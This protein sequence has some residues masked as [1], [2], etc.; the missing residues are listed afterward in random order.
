MLT[1]LRT[2]WTVVLPP[3]L[4]ASRLRGC[5]YGNWPETHTPQKREQAPALQN[6]SSVQS[7]NNSRMRLI[8][9]RATGI[10]VCFLSLIFSM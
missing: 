5:F 2:A 4:T 6:I 8:C 9:A 10:C 7:L 1:Q 3:L